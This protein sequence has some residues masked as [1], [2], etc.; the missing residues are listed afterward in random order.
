MHKPHLIFRDPREFLTQIEGKRTVVAP[1][2][3]RESGGEKKI[4]IGYC[5]WDEQGNEKGLAWRTPDPQ[6]IIQSWRALRLLSQ[7]PEIRP[8][9][10]AQC[11][12][13]ATPRLEQKGQ[14]AVQ[15]LAKVFDPAY[16]SPESLSG[17]SKFKAILVSAFTPANKF[18]EARN[19]LIQ[20]FPKQVVLE[21]ILDAYLSVGAPNENVIYEISNHVNEGSLSLTERVTELMACYS[22]QRYLELRD[23]LKLEDQ[24]YDFRQAS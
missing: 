24:K 4:A 9:T 13:A 12:Y 7:M 19:N 10:L 17:V 1:A 23:R 20:T 5:H 11:Y 3:F 8:D 22:A 6:K 21:Q 15:D 18:I 2:L 14:Q 16:E